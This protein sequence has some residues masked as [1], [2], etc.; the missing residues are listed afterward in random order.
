MPI[1]IL[2]TLATNTYSNQDK[3]GTSCSEIYDNVAYKC[4][5]E[6]TDSVPLQA[7]SSLDHVLKNLSA[8]EVDDLLNSKS[9]NLI[10]APVLRFLPYTDIITHTTLWKSDNEIKSQ[11]HIKRNYNQHIIIPFV[12]AILSIIAIGAGSIYQ[13]YDKDYKIVKAVNLCIG[14]SILYLIVIHLSGLIVGI[15]LITYFD[16]VR[17]GL[18]L[19][20][21]TAILPIILSGMYVLSEN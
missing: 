10:R 18:E 11:D 8:N 13:T 16:Y 15:L 4:T 5:K 14:T 7:G 12:L 17:A 2:L 6:T 21:M 19:L 9:I 3:R 1:V 20:F